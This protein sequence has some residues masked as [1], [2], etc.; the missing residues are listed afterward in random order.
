MKNSGY[1]EG[2]ALYIYELLTKFDIKN[3]DIIG[4]RVE[5]YGGGICTL[6][7]LEILF[8]NVVLAENSVGKYTGGGMYAEGV[9]YMGAN[10]LTIRDN[11]GEQA[12]TRGG[13]IE[14]YWCYEIYFENSKINGNKAV[15]I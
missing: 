3:S 2:G 13:G 14:F 11:I 10:N 12:L 8:E 15:N 6:Y 1:F 7:M 5:E 9:E 4:N